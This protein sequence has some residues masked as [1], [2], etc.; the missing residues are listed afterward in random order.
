MTRKCHAGDMP[1]A[2]PEEVHRCI[3]DIVSL[4]YE[5]EYR[6]RN[7]DKQDIRNDVKEEVKKEFGYRMHVESTLA[8]HLLQHPC[9]YGLSTFH[10]D[11]ANRRILEL[12][13]M[14]R[15]P[16][17]DTLEGLLLLRTAWEEYDVKMT[18]AAYYKY[19]ARFFY[20]TILV[21]GLLAVILTVFKTV[22]E[23]VV[24]CE[25][26]GTSTQSGIY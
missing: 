16:D 9:T 20:L 4:R 5:Y 25:R 8:S 24:L 1:A 11:S 12:V 6:L 17:C 15:L 23:K 14:D 26:L 19:M 22:R 21:L 13:R 2:S 18:N 3:E 10:L 7:P